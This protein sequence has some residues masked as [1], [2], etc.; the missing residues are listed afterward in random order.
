MS[1]P[2]PSSTTAS[3][4]S[5]QLLDKIA[6][7]IGA[8]S[9]LDAR[10][11]LPAQPTGVVCADLQPVAKVHVKEEDAKATHE[12]I[13]ESGCKIP[14][15]STRP[16]TPFDVPLS[17]NSR[18]V[19]LDCKYAAQQIITQ[20]SY[21]S[22]NRGYI[23]NM[24]STLGL[25]VALDS[26]NW[27]IHCNVLCPGFTKIA[28]LKSVTDVEAGQARLGPFNPFTGLGEPEDISKAAVFLASDDVSWVTGAALPVDSG[29]VAQ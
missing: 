6:I 15:P 8:V 12:V 14:Y 3:L 27:S 11:L 25:T 1:A 26:A 21:L 20:E 10:L 23:I 17:I 29:Y 18:G 24:A 7:I 19:F 4:S 9:A 13:L 22:G 2:I 28:M 5:Q 16:Q